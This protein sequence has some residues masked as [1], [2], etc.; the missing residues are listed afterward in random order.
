MFR[1]VHAERQN[2]LTQ[3]EGIVTQ[4]KSRDDEIQQTAEEFQQLKIQCNAKVSTILPA[5]L[6][7][8]SLSPLPFSFSLSVWLHRL[9][10]SARKTHSWS[11]SKPRMRKWQS[12]LRLQRSR[13]HDCEL[14]IRMQRTN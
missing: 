10:K 12:R 7:L 1:Q 4:M 6:V 5:S 2:L 8:P 3:W 13:T 11:G 14:T 9:R